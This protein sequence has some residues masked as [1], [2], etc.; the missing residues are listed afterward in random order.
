MI[1]LTTG[2]HEPFDR[3]LEAVDAWCDRS[4]SGHEIVAQATRSRI[5]PY[6]PRNFTPVPRLTPAEYADHLSRAMLVI[7]H[8]G[9]GSILSALGARKPIVVMPRRGHLRETRNDHQHATIRRFPAYPGLFVAE[10]ETVFGTVL[11]HALQCC[12]DSATP[13]ISPFAGAALTDALH[14]FFERSGRD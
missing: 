8:A 11:D 6:R 5:D 1:F 2:T 13:A 4:G 12:A 3:L 9:I 10:D 14:G 7:S